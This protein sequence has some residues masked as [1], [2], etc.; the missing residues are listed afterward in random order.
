MKTFFFNRQLGVQGITLILM[1]KDVEGVEDMLT[2]T[3]FY[4][5]ILLIS[6]LV[7]APQVVLQKRHTHT[8]TQIYHTHILEVSCADKVLKVFCS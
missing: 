6:C 8:H 5:V 4:D 7:P 3:L 1:G 2:V